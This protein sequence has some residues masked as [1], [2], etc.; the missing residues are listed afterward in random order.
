MMR[1]LE[2]ILLTGEDLQK[3]KDSVRYSKQKLD[4]LGAT[5]IVA[6]IEYIKVNNSNN[7]YVRCKLLYLNEN[8]SSRFLVC[9]ATK[10]FVVDINA[11]A[12]SSIYINIDLLLSILESVVVDYN[13]NYTIIRVGYKGF[14]DSIVIKEEY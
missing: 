14:S 10:N 4:K 13:K 11:K 3:L 1:S 9:W 5:D 6:Y 2:T 12:G 8:Q 7:H